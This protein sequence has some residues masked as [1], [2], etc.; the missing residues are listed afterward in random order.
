MF[1]VRGFG[2]S[3]IIRNVM[4]RLRRVQS[5]SRKTG[6]RNRSFHLDSFKGELLT[7]PGMLVIILTPQYNP[8][9]LP[10]PELRR[11]VKP[12]VRGALSVF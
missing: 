3:K 7:I 9:G 2:K 12:I 11:Q 8:I 5:M 10:A 6:A 4:G 1:F